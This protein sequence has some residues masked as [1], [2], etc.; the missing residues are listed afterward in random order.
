MKDKKAKLY[1]ITG[2]SGVGKG[3]VLNK[4]F[5]KNK[6]DIIY[7]VSATTR[8]PREGEKHGVNYFFI[9]KEEFEK[10]I[11]NNEFLEWA[12][13]SDNYY[14]TKKEFVLNSLKNGV[15]V[16]LEIEAQGAKKV[17]QEHPECVSIF[18]MP[19]NMEE[20]EKRLRGRKTES[21]EMILK[22]LNIVKS[23]LEEAKNYKY[24]VINDKVDQAF[25]QLQEIYEKERM[26]W[27]TSL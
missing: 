18:I 11:E 20:L 2:P 5:E 27:K 14:G 10:E 4:F 17:M 24:I 9:T 13:Y 12:K 6:G 25:R 1:V 22:R 8:K 7:S 15:S 16:I 23:E 26:L 3:T 21:E 19:P